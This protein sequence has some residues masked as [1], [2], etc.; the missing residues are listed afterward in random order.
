MSKDRIKEMAEGAK[1]GVEAEA[2]LNSEVFKVAKAASSGEI[3][4]NIYSIDIASDKEG[5]LEL[6]RSLQSMN[7]F[8]EQLEDIIGDGKF[9]QTQ[10]EQ[11][12]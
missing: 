5:A 10:L 6:I 8:I 12:N 11:E 4:Q 3:L 1:L 2:L 9:Y 7:R